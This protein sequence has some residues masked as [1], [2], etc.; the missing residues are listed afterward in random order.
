[1]H[2]RRNNKHFL[3]TNKNKTNLSKSQTKNFADA[4]LI[5]HGPPNSSP[6]KKQFL[7]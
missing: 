3:K 7:F 6:N 4:K 1:M 2:W 5:Q